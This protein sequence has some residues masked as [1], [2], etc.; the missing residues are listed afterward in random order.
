MLALTHLHSLNIVHRD[1]KPVRCL[2]GTCRHLEACTQ[3][4]CVASSVLIIDGTVQENLLLDSEGHIRITDFGL[5]KAG[6]ADGGRSNSLIGTMEYMAPEV[7]QG[8][9]H[10]K[11]RNYLSPIV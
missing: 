5:A 6:L 3:I 2:S 1:L 8:K 9:G 11:A 7:I 10:D 4:A